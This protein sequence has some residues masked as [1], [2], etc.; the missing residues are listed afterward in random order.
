L[1]ANV[2]PICTHCVECRGADDGPTPEDVDQR[3]WPTIDLGGQ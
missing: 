2:T 3:L 1:P